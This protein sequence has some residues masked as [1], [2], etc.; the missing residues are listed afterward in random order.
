[1]TT[2]AQAAPQDRAEAIARRYIASWN[3][4]DSAKR[5]QLLAELWTRDA[6]YADPMASAQGLDQIDA[7]I[8][9]VQQRFSGWRFALA[10]WPDGHGDVLRFCWQ[11]GPEGGDSLVEGTDFADLEDGRLKRVAGFLDKMPA[12]TA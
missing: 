6:S 8:D 4:T 11:L 9:A 5:R 2:N 10:G 1:M 7:M 3:E 12:G